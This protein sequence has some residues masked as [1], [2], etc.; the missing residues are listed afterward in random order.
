MTQVEK[1]KTR[2]AGVKLRPRFQLVASMLDSTHD[3]YWSK[4]C[5]EVLQQKDRHGTIKPDCAVL[6]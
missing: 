5:M 3:V 1:S 6:I 4:V 2:A